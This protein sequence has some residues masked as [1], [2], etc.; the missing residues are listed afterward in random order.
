M[1]AA[2]QTYRA[3]AGV[4]PYPFLVPAGP[5]N[6]LWDW[7][8]VM[9]GVALGSGVDAASSQYFVGSMKNFLSFTNV[10]SG[11]VQGCLQPSGPC[12]TIYHAKPIVIQGAWLA[13]KGAGASEV[14]QFR[15]FQPHMA[16]LLRYWETTARDPASGLHTWYD[17]LSSGA[18]NLVLSTCPSHYSTCWTAADAN[19]LAAPDLEAFLGREYQAYAK[20][21]KAWA[22]AATAADSAQL[23]ADAEQA[24]QAAA[25]VQSAVNQ[26]LWSDALGRYVG[27]NTTTQETITNRVFLIAFPLWSGQANATQAAATVAQ[28]TKSDLWSAYG[29]R[30]TSSDDP[31]YSNANMINP[32]SNWRGP[33]WVVANVLLSYGLF[34]YGYAKEAEELANRVVNVLAHDLTATGTWHECYSSADGAGGGDGLA[35][36]GFLSW[37]TLAASWQANLAKGVNP[38]TL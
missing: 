12:G 21:L 13:A 36:P 34:D 17:Q 33:V 28:L 14:Q 10:T 5:Y 25:A 15:Q 24:L 9:M 26:H 8:S 22:A 31:R 19:T 35:A 29:V 27:F 4:L 38:F 20:F 37:N 7:D 23:L 1:A 18:D 2:N 3:A 32:Y 11:Q 6:Q 30:S 16:A